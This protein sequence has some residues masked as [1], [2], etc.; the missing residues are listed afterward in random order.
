MEFDVRYAGGK[1]VGGGSYFW[2]G[3]R[4]KGGSDEPPEPP[5]GYGPEVTL[6]LQLYFIA[7]PSVFCKFNMTGAS[8]PHPGVRSPPPARTNYFLCL[9]LS[10]SALCTIYSSVTDGVCTGQCFL[11]EICSDTQLMQKYRDMS[12]QRGFLPHATLMI[13]VLRI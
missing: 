4:K 11:T 6:A 7:T 2:K 10:L 5:P 8:Y 12:L 9:Q 13:N 3:V 1:F